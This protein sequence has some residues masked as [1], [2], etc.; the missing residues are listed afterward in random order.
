MPLRLILM[1]PDGTVGANGQAD[2]NVLR[3]LCL[4][5]RRMATHGVQVGLWSRTLKLLNTDPLEAYLSRES[6]AQ[7]K[8][9]QAGTAQYPTRQQSGSV[10]PILAETGASRH[11]TI[12]VGSQTAD[13][14]AGV[15]NK[16]LLIRPAWYG[17]EMDYGF[18]VQSIDELARFCEVFALRQHPIYWSIDSGTVHVRS[19]G[20]FS[21]YFE[22]IAEYGAD[23]RRVA[24]EN[25]GDPNFWFFAVV[26]AL[27]FSGIVHDVDYICPFPGHDPAATGGIRELVNGVMSR[28][29]KCFNKSYF[30]D[31]IIRHTKSQKSQ[32]LKAAER[33]FLN[34]LNT[35]YLNQKPRRFDNPEP[36]KTPLSLSGK[37]IL[38]VDDFITNGRSLDV[39]RAYLAA[40]GA[41][42]VLFSW[43]KTV[44]T[45]FYHIWPNDPKLTPFQP[46]AVNTEP[47]SVSY[48]YRSCIV[49]PY[50]SQEIQRIFDAYRAWKWP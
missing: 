13:M 26:S 6:G 40:A 37:R 39:A 18:R 30:P 43:L 3:D 16:L 28:F 20:P 45:G 23:A 50:A 29:G 4:F 11:E 12:L 1:S 14:R 31:L 48:D 17:D 21:T 10:D 44:N 15:N 24:K 33:T 38:V 47:Q 7:V 9:F 41:T 8:H 5:I 36:R 49:D 42:A 2:D 22:E 34:H 32:F 19:M 25:R 46:C 35:V 27:Y